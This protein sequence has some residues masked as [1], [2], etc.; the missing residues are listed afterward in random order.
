[1]PWPEAGR[2]LTLY[3]LW[4]KYPVIS[5]S[6]QLYCA[7][8]SWGD[9]RQ[10]SGEQTLTRHLFPL[11]SVFRKQSPAPRAPV[12]SLCPPLTIT[13]PYQGEP[14]AFLATWTRGCCGLGVC[15]FLLW[16]DRWL[17]AC[18]SYHFLLGAWVLTFPSHIG[19]PMWVKVSERAKPIQTTAR[20]QFDRTV[21]TILLARRP[22]HAPQA[23][24]NKQSH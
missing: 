7:S 15:C 12:C 13:Q 11:L 19:A 3:F 23:P 1:M 9:N 6:C 5:G 22:W 24:Q 8:L 21:S 16:E 14:A 10:E 2:K 18:H 4:E 17:E 20:T